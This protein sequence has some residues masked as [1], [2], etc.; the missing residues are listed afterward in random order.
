[1]NSIVPRSPRPVFQVRE[2]FNR[3]DEV[4][5]MEREKLMDIMR[6]GYQEEVYDNAETTMIDSTRSRVTAVLNDSFRPI[7]SSDFRTKMSVAH[8]EGENA[9]Y[10]KCEVII[11]ASLEEVAAYEFKLISRKRVKLNDTQD[12]LLRDAKNINNHALDYITEREFGFG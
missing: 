4:D 1:M 7:D 8:V 2:K 11:D 5:K 6:S 3:D 10:A 9:G 12:M